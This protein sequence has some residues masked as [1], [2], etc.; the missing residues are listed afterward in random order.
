MPPDMYWI[1]GEP[2]TVDAPATKGLLMKNDNDINEQPAPDGRPLGFWL[3]LVDAR[4]TEALDAEFADEGIDRRTWMALNLLAGDADDQ[5]LAKLA[6]KR[7][8]AL[9]QHLQEQGWAAPDG[10]GWTL[11]DSGRAQRDAMKERIEAVRARVL[12]AVTPDEYDTLVAS[13]DK[14]A[15][16]F[17]WDGS[18]RMP[19]G[20]G[21]GGWFGRGWG[22]GWG[23]GFQPGFQPG[24]GPG[25]GPGH[26]LGPGHGFD[27]SHGFG[28]DHGR[29]HGLDPRHDAEGAPRPFDGERGNAHRGFGPGEGPRHGYGPRG[30]GRGFGPGAPCA[31]GEYGHA[32][33]GHH[34]HGHGGGHRKAERAYERGFEAGAAAASRVSP[35]P[36]D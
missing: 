2:T 6:R 5:R 23:R 18:E 12:E 33:G 31:S 27:S 22:R 13:L 3:R 14:I 35:A 24:F 11:T 9:L 32:H 36:Q 16:R 21:F 29:G 10:D 25:F 26:G 4:L 15:R 1:A 8:G 17:G 34:R 20:R 28:P 7:G 30:F 19:R